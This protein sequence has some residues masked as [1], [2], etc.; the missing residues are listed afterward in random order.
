MEQMVS[1]QVD[2]HDRLAMRLRNDRA[3]QIYKTGA[4]GMLIDFSSLGLVDSSI[5]QMFSNIAGTSRILDTD[6]VVA[7]MQPAVAIPTLDRSQPEHSIDAY[8]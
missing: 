4:R 8:P 5:G 2:R 6:T 3:E 7:G 1:I